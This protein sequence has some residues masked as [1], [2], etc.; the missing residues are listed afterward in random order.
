MIHM[1]WYCCI[2]IRFLLAY[3]LSKYFKDNKYWN[4]EYSKWI[5]LV[6]G[7]GFTYKAWTGSNNET[8]ITKVFWHETRGIH[9][10]LYLLAFFLYIVK[11]SIF[12][13]SSHVLMCDIIF[14][15][16]YRIYLETNKLYTI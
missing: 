14:S 13:E 6:I 1:L 16:I 11:S 10:F 4:S 8:Q 9:A 3:S 5:I 15:I 12:V 2:I 7:L